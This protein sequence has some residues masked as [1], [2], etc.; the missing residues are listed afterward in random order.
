MPATAASSLPPAATSATAPNPSASSPSDDSDDE[1]DR[2]DPDWDE[3]DGDAPH[4]SKPVLPAALRAGA[5]AP[6]SAGSKSPGVP[7][8]L[9]AGPPAGSPAKPRESYFDV[10]VP[11]TSAYSPPRPPPPQGHNPFL[12]PQNSGSTGHRLFGGDSSENV[13]VTPLS[14]SAPL[15]ELPADGPPVGKIAQMSLLDEPIP[16]SPQSAQPALIPVDSETDV[17]NPQH[18]WRNQQTSIPRGQE[19]KGKEAAHA[20][21][22]ERQA[23]SGSA[24]TSPPVTSPQAATPPVTPPKVPNSVNPRANDAQFQQLIP[25][26]TDQPVQSTPKAE[27]PGAVMKR[28]KKENYQIKHIRWY[29][30][31]AKTTR[32]SPILTQN[33]NGPC[34]LLALVNALALSTPASEQ[35]ALV[36]A[37]RTREHVSLGLLLDVVFDELMSGRRGSTQELPDVDDLY[38]F[39]LT[40]HTGMNV[41]PRFT[42]K[43]DRASM[44]MHPALRPLTQPGGFEET[45]EMRLYST[46]NVPLMHGWLPPRDSAEYAAFER[47]AKTYED[48]QN[49]QFH[50]EELEVKL[51]TTGMNPQEQDLFEDLITIKEF[52]A[53]WPTQLTQ[54]GLDVIR[55]HL[56]PGEFAILFRN[57]HFSTIYMEPRSRQILTLVTDAG[58]SS[59]D[60][61]V[62]ES[63][64]DVNGK[65]SQLFSGD[66][67]P[68]SHDAPS[69]GPAGPRHSSLSQRPVQSMLDVDDRSWNT[70]Q[71][72]RSKPNTTQETGIIGASP[73][74]PQPTSPALSRIEQE[75]HD[76]ALALQL[77]EEEE[78]RH[79]REQD[80]RRR[81]EQL[82]DR[83]MEHRTPPA[84]VPAAR[85]AVPPRRPRAPDEE[86]PPPTY[87]QSSKD[88]RFNPPS[89][90]PANPAAPVRSRQS[91]SAYAQNASVQPGP[92]PTGRRHSRPVPLVDQ[93]P[94]GNG[95]GRG[96]RPSQI[97]AVHGPGVVEERERCVVM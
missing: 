41:N 11:L 69:P 54:Y 21:S 39:L 92:G 76:L 53:Q 50:E 89:G 90:H 95:M 49:I 6:P 65:A 82:R 48:A 15:A 34:P 33:A 45:R 87:E 68:V 46:F 63:L 8:S 1:W 80:T 86:P 81:N 38:K 66:F 64:V 35:T 93:I 59:H 22:V 88:R 19:T 79:R 27:S 67:R 57:D 97:H 17:I 31:A 30:A 58:Y 9:R 83:V 51:S 13:W 77:Q 12:R 55:E 10:N 72:K 18:A 29:D 84:P 91:S 78:D 25:I 43:P 4:N 62:W 26:D 52:L 47:S 70:V 61:I 2:S 14:S 20:A 5:P 7:A 73:S 60:E 56:R 28:Q 96:R 74:A 94:H 23:W 16:L 3:M 42:F 37:L 75:D 24:I 85:P 32:L 71:G 44:D 40:L 36:E